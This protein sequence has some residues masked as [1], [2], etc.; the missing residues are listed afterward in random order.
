MLRLFADILDVLFVQVNEIGLLTEFFEALQ[1]DQGA[2][3]LRP[4]MMATRAASLAFK[5]DGLK[6]GL[7]ENAG[8][9]SSPKKEKKG[10]TPGLKR[11]LPGVIVG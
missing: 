6:S 9:N 4:L 7:Y 11:L 2:E 10:K 3:L 1:R 5:S 8:Q